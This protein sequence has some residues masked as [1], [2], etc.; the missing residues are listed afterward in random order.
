VKSQN[1][2]EKD[3]LEKQ[4]ASLQDA[5]ATAHH[6][7]SKMKSQQ[8]VAAPKV[9]TSA[10][11]AMK[12][13]IGELE[14]SI[15]ELRR[16]HADEKEKLLAASRSDK[17]HYN[18]IIEDLEGDLKEMTE[19]RDVA[20]SDMMKLRLR[21]DELER[22]SKE[23][24]DGDSSK[25]L[26][27][28]RVLRTKVEHLEIEIV[29][30]RGKREREVKTLRDKLAAREL[31]YEAAQAELGE[32]AQRVSSKSGDLI[33]ESEKLNAELTNALEEI[34]RLRIAKEFVS[35]EFSF[36]QIE[37]SQNSDLLQRKLE[38]TQEQLND[39]EVEL[40]KL[41]AEVKAH[42]AEQEQL[43]LES[44]RLNKAN[45]AKLARLRSDI[46]SLKTTHEQTMTAEVDALK[47]K[48]EDLEDALDDAKMAAAAASQAQQNTGDDEAL[49]ARIAQLEP[50]LAA[51]KEDIAALEEEA[52]ANQ[53]ALEYTENWAKMNDKRAQGAEEFL[54][55]LK[56]EVATLKKALALAKTQ[57]ADGSAELQK[58]LDECNENCRAQMEEINELRSERDQ[59]TLK[60]EPVVQ[61]SVIGSEIINFDIGEE[62][63]VIPDIPTRAE[64][65]PVRAPPPAPRVTEPVPRVA[66]PAPLRMEERLSQ[67][68]VTYER[69]EEDYDEP[70][71]YEQEYIEDHV[72]EETE[73]IL[74]I[75]EY[76]SDGNEVIVESRV[77]AEGEEVDMDVLAK[78]E[79]EKEREVR[80]EVSTG[81]GF[82]NRFGAAANDIM[83]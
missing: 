35:S 80:N 81:G 36:Y 65:E 29:S 28:I 41:R 50:E 12:S 1:A 20:V 9:D 74:E 45:D 13:R 43:M 51:A 24:T 21:L 79:V 11:D 6:E 22:S 56:M 69:H 15:I 67:T 68:T 39:A 8:P 19:S 26:I 83:E 72:I 60:K 14:N 10:L 7:K 49:K 4:I 31:E 46:I 78:G 48:I 16:T 5:L 18:R 61:E 54:I 33:K 38:R 76:D 34:E 75:I 58:L 59:L 30:E 52:R 62:N 32:E 3:L 47:A 37:A 23:P 53:A 25:L 64:P 40:A 82:W 70:E 71:E 27:E 57:P 66:E 42:E 55:S 17:R 2:D 44:H 77:L 73:E 63:F